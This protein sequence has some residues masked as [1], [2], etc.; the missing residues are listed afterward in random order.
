M[1]TPKTGLV[2]RQSTSPEDVLNFNDLL[3]IQQLAQGPSADGLMCEYKDGFSD[4]TDPAVMCPYAKKLESGCMS[5]LTPEKIKTMTPDEMMKAGQKC[6]A[7]MC[8]EITAGRFSK[9][10]KKCIN[11]ACEENKA[12][13]DMFDK[14]VGALEKTGCRLLGAFDDDADEDKDDDEDVDE[15]DDEDEAQ[16]TPSNSVNSGFKTSTTTVAGSTK[17]GDAEETADE[18]ASGAV[19]APVADEESSA[20]RLGSGWK[21]TALVGALVFGSLFSMM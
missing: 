6:A 11:T 18:D 17:T 5:D 13:M 1:P 19:N 14:L 12:A 16:P 10:L 15:D 4:K 3:S 20:V 21:N 2:T 7:V 8:T 9:E